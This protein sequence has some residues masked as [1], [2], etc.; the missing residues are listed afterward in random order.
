MKKINVNYNAESKDFM[1]ALGLPKDK[2]EEMQEATN[3][4]IYD[5]IEEILRKKEYNTQEFFT[6]LYDNHTP[7]E[8]L[9]L[10]A[11]FLE[12]FVKSIVKEMSLM[13][14]LKPKLDSPE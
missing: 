13:S 6:Y 5:F 12:N 1:E 7:E 2:A 3:I 9:M 14:A 11:K 10:A 4:K 8:I